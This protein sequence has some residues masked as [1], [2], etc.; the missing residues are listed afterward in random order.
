MGLL[1]NVAAAGGSARSCAVVDRIARRRW[2]RRVVIAAAGQ[3]GTSCRRWRSPTRCGLSGAEVVFVGGERAEARA[4][5]GGR[6]RAAHRSRSS[7]LSRSNPLRRARALALAGAGA[8]DGRAAILR[9]LRPDAVIGAGGYVA[10]PVGLAAALLRVPLVLTEADSHLGIANRA[11]RA[12][13]AAGVPGVPDRRARRRP[14]PASPAGRCPP[15][16]TDR[17]PRARRFGLGEDETCVL[18]FGGSLGARSINEAAVDGVRPAA[19]FRVLHACGAARLRRRCATPR[20]ARRHYDL[21]EPTSRRSATRWR[22]PT[23]CVARAGG[24]VF[25]VAAAGRPAMLVPYPHATADHQTGNAR[26]MERRR[27]RGGR[28]RRRA[29]RPRGWRR[30][31][32]ALLGDRGAPARRWRARRR[33]WRGR[34]PRSGSRPR[35]SPPRRRD[36]SPVRPWLWQHRARSRRSR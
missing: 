23:S 22:R 18:V 20:A 33:R 2:R 4:R 3:R 26:W 12:L 14:L 1:L 8:A 30:E 5:A 28:A 32:A 34:T 11:A 24:S 19:P 25:E 31:V 29:R 10:G 9:E 6:L 35:C 15:P 17:A 7:G 27:R 16:A 36:R 21:R 13:R